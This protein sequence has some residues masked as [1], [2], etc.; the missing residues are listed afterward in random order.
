MSDFED[1]ALND[2]GLVPKI[3]GT[4]PVERN[5]ISWVTPNIGIS[6]AS[7]SS[8]PFDNLTLLRKE[9]F[10]INVAHDFEGEV[11]WYDVKIPLGYEHIRPTQLDMIAS[12]IDLCL[13]KRPF[14]IV[15]CI[16]GEER[17]PLAVAWYLMTKGMPMKNAMALV[18]DTRSVAVDRTNWIVQD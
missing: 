4:R 7:V 13:K 17:S 11:P 9:C 18:M 2:S 16:A 8:L 15:H 5:D 12:I 6:D 14:V 10:V 3:V 1:Q